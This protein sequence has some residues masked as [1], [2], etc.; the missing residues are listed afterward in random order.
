[1]KIAVLDTGVSFANWA[2]YQHKIAEQRSWVGVKDKKLG[3][4]FSGENIDTDGHGT[5]TTSVLMETSPSCEVYVAKVFEGRR[6]KSGETPVEAT[7]QAIA[8]VR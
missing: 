6:E 5:H 8:N 7:Q 2:L 3:A 4:N 1:M